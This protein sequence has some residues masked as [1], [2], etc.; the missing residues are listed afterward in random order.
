[1]EILE[2]FEEEYKNIL[3]K[4]DETSLTIVQ[5]KQLIVDLIEIEKQMI[6]LLFEFKLSNKN[7]DKLLQI[8]ESLAV[9]ARNLLNS[10]MSVKDTIQKTMTY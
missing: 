1:M 5:S 6:N 10:S 2:Y 9:N 7:L 4:V 8:V 3:S